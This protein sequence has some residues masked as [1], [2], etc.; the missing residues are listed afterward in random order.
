MEPFAVGT[1]IVKN[2]HIIMEGDLRWEVDFFEE[3]NEGLILVEVELQ[4]L[5]TPIAIPEWV[6]KEVSEDPRY[7]NNQLAMNPYKYWNTKP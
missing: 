2:R 4:D 5:A 3:E 1:P 7:L 6:G